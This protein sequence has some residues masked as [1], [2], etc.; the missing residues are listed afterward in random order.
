M[1]SRVT[2]N[3]FWASKVADH[4]AETVKLKKKKLISQIAN[5]KYDT[6]KFDEIFLKLSTVFEEF[7][8]EVENKPFGIKYEILIKKKKPI[9]FNALLILCSEPIYF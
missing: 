7:I 6:G 3:I 4:S 9:H 2:G 8:H 1:V 5:Y